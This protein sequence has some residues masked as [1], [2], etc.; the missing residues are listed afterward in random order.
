MFMLYGIYFTLGAPY[1]A[2]QVIFIICKLTIQLM[3]M[4]D[5]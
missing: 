4:N 2:R 1:Y 3:V 5:R